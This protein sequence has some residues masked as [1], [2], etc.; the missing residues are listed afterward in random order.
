ML[1][2]WKLFFYKCFILWQNQFMLIYFYISKSPIWWYVWDL[3]NSRHMLLHLA[4]LILTNWTQQ[5]RPQLMVIFS[6]P[7]WSLKISLTMIPFSPFRNL[8]W[9]PDRHQCH[10]R[11]SSSGLRGSV[12]TAQWVQSIKVCS[13]AQLEVSFFPLSLQCTLRLEPVAT[14]GASTSILPPPR[15]SRTRLKSHILSATTLPSK[16]WKI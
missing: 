6:T 13:I 3:T 15:H 5:P 9:H 11:Q 7:Y 16:P 14:L 2:T 10:F 12:R 4:D 1:P 8:Y